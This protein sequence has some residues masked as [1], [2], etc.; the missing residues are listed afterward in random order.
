MGMVSRS[1]TDLCTVKF[2]GNV[3]LDGK[4]TY[5]VF[6]E[7]NKGTLFDDVYCFQELYTAYCKLFELETLSFYCFP[8]HSAQFFLPEKS[9]L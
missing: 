7:T 4:C 1:N 5:A 9:F 3:L 6:V 2:P 8:Q